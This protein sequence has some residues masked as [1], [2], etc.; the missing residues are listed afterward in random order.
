MR[1]IAEV[2]EDFASGLRAA[3]R[4]HPQAVNVRSKEAFQPGIGRHSESRTV[5]LVAAA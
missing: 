4:R 5:E 2:V 3:D 1:T